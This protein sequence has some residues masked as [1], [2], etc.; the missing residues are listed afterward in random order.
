MY[1]DEIMNKRYIRLIYLTLILA[2]IFPVMMLWAAES[3]SPNVDNGLMMIFV[4]AIFVGL[5]SARYTV[6][7]LII[8]LTTVATGFLLLGYVVMPG[9]EKIALIVA[10][11]IE[12]S[13]L[14]V[15]RHHI[16]RWKVINTREEDVKRYVVH[17]DL[18]VKLQTY[19]NADKFY[20]RELKQIK[21]YSDLNLWVNVELVAWDRWQQLREYYPDEYLRILRHIAD[22]LK[23][24][25]L[26]N[27]F[28]YYLGQ[29]T[30]MIISPQISDEIVQ[31]INQKTKTGLQEINLSV[32]IQ[33]KTAMQK[34]DK[35]NSKKFAELEPLTRH[36]YRGLETDIIVEY[37]KDRQHD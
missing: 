10:F 11:P 20:R 29:G 9:Y 27:E 31:K 7:W 23:M 12:A 37:L 17:Y 24:T 30:F 13:L 14:S 25:R 36:L 8:I 18:N 26:K 33:L 15:L 3:F 2:L 22:V 34:V 16:L 4:L 19:Y 1:W 6:S 5:L 21:D 28:I 32:P 35:N